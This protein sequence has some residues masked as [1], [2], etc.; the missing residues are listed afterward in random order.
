MD[1]IYHYEVRVNWDIGGKE[2][3]AKK[4]HRELLNILV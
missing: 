4:M 2:A 3:N 1:N